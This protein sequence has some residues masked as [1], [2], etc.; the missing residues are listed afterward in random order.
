MFQIIQTLLT[1][2]LVGS[3]YAVFSIF[4][5]NE[6]GEE[7][8]YADFTN[9]LQKVY[10]LFLMLVV[11]FSI[12]RK[13]ETASTAFGLGSFILGIFMVLTIY[14]S[15]GWLQNHFANNNL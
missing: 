3:F 11:M 10:I 5:E 4:M 12:T 6:F 7:Q 15:V 9:I 1:F 13:V 8:A 14:N 2:V